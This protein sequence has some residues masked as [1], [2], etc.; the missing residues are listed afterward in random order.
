MGE[1]IRSWWAGT[2]AKIGMK[3]GEMCQDERYQNV[4]NGY[5]TLN[6]LL[7]KW[8]PEQL[9]GDEIIHMLVHG[10]QVRRARAPVGAHRC[11]HAHPMGTRPPRHTHIYMICDVYVA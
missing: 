5:G 9:H 1:Y 11:P 2:A 7:F 10:P 8:P 3:T 6:W 4:L